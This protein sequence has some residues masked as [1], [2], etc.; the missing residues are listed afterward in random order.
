MSQRKP[1]AIRNY[2]ETDQQIVGFN[3]FMRVVVIK[4]ELN[5]IKK[6]LSQDHMTTNQDS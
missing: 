2:Q 4:I 3:L 6:E 5:P 1:N